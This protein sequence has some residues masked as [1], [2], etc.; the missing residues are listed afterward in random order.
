MN[1]LNSSGDIGCPCSVPTV[2]S[3]AADSFLISFIRVLEWLYMKLIQ[4][5]PAIPIC[6]SLD[7]SASLHTVSNAFL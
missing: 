2:T 4:W 3:I 1:S 7:W 6:L 5:L